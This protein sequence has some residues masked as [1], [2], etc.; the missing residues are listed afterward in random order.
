[1]P[2][3]PTN[4]EQERMLWQ[5]REAAE[6]MELAARADAHVFR[7]AAWVW[8]VLSFFILI[9]VVTAWLGTVGLGGTGPVAFI[10]FFAILPLLL[11]A[12]ITAMQV[13]GVIWRRW[14]KSQR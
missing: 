7:R 4:R 14:R 13:V 3:S 11:P 1:M 6:E 5:Q 9:G 2:P 10:T 8:G 12:A